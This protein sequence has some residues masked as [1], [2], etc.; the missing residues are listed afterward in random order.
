MSKYD[1]TKF[2]CK[3][4]CGEQ[5]LWIPPVIQQGLEE[6]AQTMHGLVGHEITQSVLKHLNVLYCSSNMVV[7]THS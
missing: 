5:M 6:N 1:T 2:Y 7:G 4:Q 3:C